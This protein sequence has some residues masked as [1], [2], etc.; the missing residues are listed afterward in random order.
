MSPAFTTSNDVRG[1]YYTVINQLTYFKIE[2]RGV[3]IFSLIHNMIPYFMPNLKV[4]DELV[5]YFLGFDE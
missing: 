2:I 1:V 4:L 3:Q 5:V